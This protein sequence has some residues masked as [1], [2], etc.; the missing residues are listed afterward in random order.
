M[1]GCD[2]DNCEIEW[3]HL[4]CVGLT[5]DTRPGE[6]QEWYVLFYVVADGLITFRQVL[7]DLSTTP[8]AKWPERCVQ[9]T[10]KFAFGFRHT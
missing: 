9:R 10:A 1:I 6:N 7:S 3:F 2:N 8:S 5:P 4:E